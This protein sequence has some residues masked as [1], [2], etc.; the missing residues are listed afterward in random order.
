[1]VRIGGGSTKF[2]LS[3]R[4]TCLEK[5]PFTGLTGLKLN[6]LFLSRLAC[7]N[8]WQGPLA[9]QSVQLLNDGQMSELWFTSS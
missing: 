9:R 6:K 1:M 8:A 3:D 2:V 5:R 4:C 7:M